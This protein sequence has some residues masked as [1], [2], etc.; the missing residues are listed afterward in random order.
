MSYRMMKSIFCDDRMFSAQRSE[1]LFEIYSKYFVRLSNVFCYGGWFVVFSVTIR[2][3]RVTIEYVLLRYMINSVL[4]RFS[5]GHF[6][7]SSHRLR[8]DSD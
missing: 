5:G 6:F 1:N 8:T 7:F 3:F 4:A 2:L